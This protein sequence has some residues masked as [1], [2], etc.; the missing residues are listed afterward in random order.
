[1]DLTDDYIKSECDKAWVE[2]GKKSFWENQEAVEGIGK[3]LMY[4]T[5]SYRGKFENYL[6]AT[7]QNFMR[8]MTNVWMLKQL[9]D[10]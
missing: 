1:M 8:R 7:M 6:S 3:A 5:A 2:C 9:S 10:K 4:Y